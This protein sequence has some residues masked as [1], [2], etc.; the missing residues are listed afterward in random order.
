ML[1]RRPERIERAIQINGHL[2]TP[3]FR[4][5]FREGFECGNGSIRLID[6]ASRHLVAELRGHTDYVHA[7]A[8]G[9]DGQLWMT[10]GQGETCPGCSQDKIGRLDGINGSYSSWVL[11]TQPAYPYRI[12]HG[13]DGFGLV[14][15]QNLAG[16]PYVD[17]R[18]WIR[19][20]R[21]RQRR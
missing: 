8:W 3:G 12:V 21:R 1:G 5:N 7:V 16:D 14:D 18:E 20:R 13:P 9:P 6:V 2:A 19:R 4:G 10:E 11:P 15:S 17:R